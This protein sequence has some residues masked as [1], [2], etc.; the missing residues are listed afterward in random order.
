MPNGAYQGC[1][2][3]G[4]TTT[5]ESVENTTVADNGME[6]YINTNGTEAFGLNHDGTCDVYNGE[7]DFNVSKSKCL[8][9]SNGEWVAKFSYGSIK[10]T[11]VCANNG[12]TYDTVG[13]PN[14]NNGQYCWCKMTHSTN[15]SLSSASS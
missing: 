7:W 5:E 3:S 10:G 8:G 14:G 6:S 1:D 15:S 13:N 4:G 12:G 2:C 9:L 11:S